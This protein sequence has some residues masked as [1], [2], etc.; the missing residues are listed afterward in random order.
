MEYNYKLFEEKEINGLF[1]HII[2]LCKGL[3]PDDHLTIICF[4]KNEDLKLH[5]HK[6]CDFDKN[7]GFGNI[8]CISTE[9]NDKYV[10]DVDNVYVSDGSLYHQ[11][12]RIYNYEKFQTLYY[13]CQWRLNCNMQKNNKNKF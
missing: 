2:E 10:D 8:V 9:Q 6:D 7:T 12:K 3:C 13:L 11:L 5:I 1:N 4:G